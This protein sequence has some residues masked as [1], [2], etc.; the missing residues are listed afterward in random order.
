MLSRTY[1]LTTRHEINYILTGALW[2]GYALLEFSNEQYFK[3]LQVI[4]ITAATL[5]S[6]F[7]FAFKF[8]EEDEMSIKNM[9]RAK[10]V[11]LDLT[12]V[13]IMI[14]GFVYSCSYL[15]H[16]HYGTAILF[17]NLPVTFWTWFSVGI[18]HVITGSAF[19]YF[20]GNTEFDEE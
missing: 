18:A 16:K 9:N 12:I 14:F 5:C 15:M 11:A 20:E 1:S 6:V 10:S 7:L 19:V 8:E 2:I 13:A 17:D 3:L 4:L